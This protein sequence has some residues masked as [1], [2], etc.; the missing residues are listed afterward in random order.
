[1]IFKQAALGDERAFQTAKNTSGVSI[2]LGYGATL[3]ISGT[4]SFDG[5]QIV[6]SNSA[7][8]SNLPGFL[9]IAAAN[10]PTGQFGLLQ[11]YGNALSVLVSMQSTSITINAGDPLIPSPLAGGFS[12]AVPSYAASGFN[13]IICSN[14][15]TNTI[16]ALATAVTYVSGYLRCLK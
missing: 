11:I 6:L 7:T 2:T 8:A 1:M 4:A 15:P 14:P 9:G 13:W 5:T 12:S 3:A 16:S 10:I